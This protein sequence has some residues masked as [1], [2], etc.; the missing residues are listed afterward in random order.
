MQPLKKHKENLVL[1]RLWMR[2]EVRIM[3]KNGASVNQEGYGTG[4]KRLRF[5]FCI[6]TVLIFDERGF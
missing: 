4:W 2:T 5:A 3:Q 1:P 6:H